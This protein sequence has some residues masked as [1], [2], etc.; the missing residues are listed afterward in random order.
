MALDML[1]PIF[2]PIWKIMVFKK[3]GQL[4]LKCQEG[5]TLDWLSH[6]PLLDISCTAIIT[7]K[8]LII[9]VLTDPGK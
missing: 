8:R 4:E 7:T 1:S 5:M 2:P 6:K 9:I 3:G